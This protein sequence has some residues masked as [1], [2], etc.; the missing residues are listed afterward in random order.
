MR[1]FAS[2]QWW[3]AWRVHGRFGVPERGEF[4][5]KFGSPVAKGRRIHA[6]GRQVGPEVFQFALNDGDFLLNHALVGQR[7]FRCCVSC[8][9]PGMAHGHSQGKVLDVQGRDGAC[10]HELAFFECFNSWNYS[11]RLGA[12][13]CGPSLKAKVCRSNGK[14][15]PAGVGNHV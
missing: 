1:Q 5:A 12:I 2:G 3:E 11:R 10:V 15:I 13:H 4:R 14:L 7:L 9:S 6:I 8:A